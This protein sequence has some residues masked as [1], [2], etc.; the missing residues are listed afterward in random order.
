MHVLI[1]VYFYACSPHERGGC[2]ERQD[3]SVSV[4][5]SEFSLRYIRLGSERVRQ[6]Q[7][8]AVLKDVSAVMQDSRTCRVSGAALH[9]GNTAHVIEHVCAGLCIKAEVCGWWKISFEDDRSR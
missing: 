6:S 2:D 1:D 9:G 5:D 4:S 8:T 7:Q 3:V